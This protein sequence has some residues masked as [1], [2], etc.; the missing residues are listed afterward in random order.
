M[1]MAYAS[2]SA[3][4]R[5]LNSHDVNEDDL[6]GSEEEDQIITAKNKLS[7]TWSLQLWFQQS[8]ND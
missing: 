3:L 5:P 7:S 2:R 4:S 1:D 8:L 6:Y